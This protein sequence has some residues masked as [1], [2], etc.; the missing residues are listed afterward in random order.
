L[1]KS[2]DTIQGMKD[3][4]NTLNDILFAEKDADKI[5][6]ESIA[7]MEE[8]LSLYKLALDN[9]KIGTADYLRLV[10]KVA[11]VDAALKK[12]R[13]SDLSGDDEKFKRKEALADIETYHNQVNTII[14][15]QYAEGLI[16][17]DQYLM[18]LD[19]E[20]LRYQ[21]AAIA[22]LK[23]FGQDTSAE[24]EKLQ[25]TLVSIK[26]AGI[27]ETEKAAKDL[28]DQYDDFYKNWDKES[29]QFLKDAGQYYELPFDGAEKILEE[30]YRMQ[31]TLEGQ[32][33]KI[34]N[35]HYNLHIIGETE[36]LD[37]LDELDK[38]AAEKKMQRMEDW[39]R[40]ASMTFDAVGNMFEAAKNRELSV[41]G[42]TDKEKQKIELKYAKRQQAIAETQA[43]IEGILEIA[44][45]NSN[46][47]VNAD[48]TQTLR[49]VLTG[50]AVLRT[51]ANISLIESQQFSRGKYPV[52][53]ATDGRIYQASLLGNVKTGYYSK[54]T[55]GL[56]SERE[57]EIVID[58]P[59][60][61]NIKANFP[62]I[63]SAINSARVNQFAGGKY[64]D[65]GGTG[66]QSAMQLT[67]LLQANM[68]MMR[69]VILAHEK[70]GTVSFSSIR[71][72]QAEFDYIKS[73]TTI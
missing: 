21:A 1:Q 23:K 72:T 68:Q 54:P 63:L 44:K 12:A 15:A 73:K 47:G 17:K 51:A 49:A 56:F 37:K 24:E 32:R 46:T 39:S 36:M 55:L 27:K 60:T 20:D 64:P 33:D 35:D 5:G 10:K 38:K 61:R 57:P 18:D 40:A 70:P 13:G 11:D 26:D 69:Q 31:T 48:L 58:G 41:A 67:A 6:M 66:S 14:K 3:Q 53:G 9:A 50:A 4:K 52:K 25:G 7:M 59:T 42:L 28:Q 30:D 71:N 43:V 29:I 62:E 8:K 45:I 22:R 2:A 34:R 65:L 19:T 16:D